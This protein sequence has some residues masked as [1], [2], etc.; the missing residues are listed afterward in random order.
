MGRAEMVLRDAPEGA[1]RVR[2]GRRSVRAV[3]AL[4]LGVRHMR[5][6]W[7]LLVAVQVGMIAALLV[8]CAVPLFSQVAF[9]TGL[10]G[11]VNR[12]AA[13]RQLSADIS[14]NAPSSQLMSQVE[15]Q[16]GQYVHT[17]LAGA[18]IR[19]QGAP[20]V[21]MSTP[22]LQFTQPSVTT[23][24][25]VAQAAGLDSSTQSGNDTL[26]SAGTSVQP[27]SS[28]SGGGYGGISLY[29][30]PHDQLARK[31][32]LLDGHLPQARQDGIEILIT[33]PTASKLH[34]QMGSRLS[35]DVVAGATARP[36]VL[37]VAGIFASTKLNTYMNFDPVYAGPT[38]TQ[39]SY[40]AVVDR[41]VIANSAYPWSSVALPGQTGLQGTSNPRWLIT[42]IYQLDVSRLTPDGTRL[43]LQTAPSNSNYPISLNSALPQ[44][45]QQ[46]IPANEDTL[47]I[48]VELL[49]SLDA[50]QRNIV[51][52][53]IVVDVL[54]LAIV[55]L[56]VLFVAQMSGLLIERQEAFIALLRSRGASRRQIFVTF[57]MQGLAMVLVAMIAGPLL[58]VPFIRQVALVLF[59]VQRQSVTDALAGNP[60]TL[61]LGL[62]PVTLV[63]GV[64]VGLAVLR[65]IHRASAL[66][67]LALRQDSARSRRTPLWRKLYLDVF[68]ALLALAGYGTLAM[69][70]SIMASTPTSQNAST[71]EGIAP[72]GLV[73][74][75]FL[76][77]AITLL[78]LRVFPLVLRLS[79]WLAARG[80]GAPAPLAFAQLARSARQSTQLIVLLALATGFALM[81]ASAL[82]TTDH[83]TTNAATFDA[84]SDFSGK[85]INPLADYRQ[86]AGVQSAAKG[87]ITGGSFIAP[88]KQ[89]QDWNAPQG[90]LVSA[91]ES[92]RYAE[93]INWPDINGT[94][95]VSK[96]MSLLRQEA[97]TA[98]LANAVPA[99]VDGSTHARTHA[100]V[101]T[102]LTL[103]M[104]EVSAR[105]VGFRVVAVVQ[106][107][108][109]MYADQPTIGG[110]M[111]VDYARYMQAVAAANGTATITQLAPNY[112]WL[113]TAG[114]SA[115]LH[116]L[117]A[118]L[119]SGPYQLNDT[120]ANGIYSPVELTTHDRRSEI[121]D[122]HSDALY[123]DLLGTLALGAAAALLLALLGTIVT[124][125]TATGDRRVSFA[126]LRA[127]GSG[128]RRIRRMVIWEQ[129][130]VCAVGLALGGLLS[131][132][133]TVA[134]APTLPALMFSE[135]FGGQI[136]RGGLP[137]RIVWP[138][139][140][141]ALI[142]GVLV[143]VCAGT[144]VLAAR[145]AAR[146]ALAAVLRLNED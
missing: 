81:V 79:E 94:G 26:L 112:V 116:S 124:L 89:P 88:G 16:V 14:T 17:Y 3:A 144:M 105:P 18:N 85:P 58:A 93:T 56:M 59:S 6:A 7:R 113:R 110:G 125:W 45:G 139:P 103:W 23:N 137:A 47:G 129:A 87:Y 43:L 12:T 133:L 37:Y 123:V 36:L 114:D 21:S 39:P 35:L 30:Y 104:P 78:F 86:L 50:F 34:L 82:A 9:Y 48:Y 5:P 136:Q 25:A 10:R 77:M 138:T 100:S 31:I 40:Y 57:A 107:I 64:V 62:W 60:I 118:A 55:G 13:N 126:L 32:T 42:W 70:N 28:R 41:D 33:A 132:L 4:W 135:G 84:G 75:L 119:T 68:A 51:G 19:L 90:M 1:R 63:A 106:H 71:L 120:N 95:S 127:L 117:R 49:A 101:G 46:A 92:E 122:L 53:Q 83:Y 54:L 38:A 141:L 24:G 99:I 52:A 140:S 91:V 130:F 11:V 97:P 96:L 27:L 65:A 98:D 74:P 2:A 134:M 29:A 121:A 69:A 102:I 146:P 145:A 44:S 61:A 15:T 131:M 80:R 111:L 143:I 66:N 8:T 142:V 128:P 72:L 108:P 73:A 22:P 115:S 20:D 67:I 109:Q 76:M